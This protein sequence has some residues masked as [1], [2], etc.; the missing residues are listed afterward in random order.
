VISVKGNGQKR[1]HDVQ[2]DDHDSLRQGYGGPPELHAKADETMNTM[3]PCS[4]AFLVSI[5]PSWSSCPG[6]R[7]VQQCKVGN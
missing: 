5:V 6:R 3:K 4:E 7:P 2:H 1:D